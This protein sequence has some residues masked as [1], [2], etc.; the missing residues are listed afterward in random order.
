M[1]VS[2]SRSPN[3]LIRIWVVIIAVIFGFS[4][5]VFIFRPILKRLC[6]L[7]TNKCLWVEYQQYQNSV[8]AHTQPYGIWIWYDGQ[9]VLVY[10]LP[11]GRQCEDAGF[12]SAYV[13]D[14]T[15]N[16]L[17]GWS[18]ARSMDEV[19]RFYNEKKCPIQYFF[20]RELPSNFDVY[21]FINLLS[22]ERIISLKS[23]SQCSADS[24]CG[25]G[26]ICQAGTCVAGFTP[27]TCKVDTDCSQG[28]QCKDGVCVSQ[29]DCQK[30]AP[31]LS[32]PNQCSLNGDFLV[33]SD[34]KLTTQPTTNI[35]G[36]PF[37]NIEDTN[38]CMMKCAN[39][40][41][42]QLWSYDTDTKTCYGW[43][44][45]I[46]T[47]SQGLQTSKGNLLG[48]YKSAPTAS[49]GGTI[50]EDNSDCTYPSNCQ[51]YV[52]KPDPS[53]NIQCDNVMIDCPRK[54][55]CQTIQGMKKCVVP[56]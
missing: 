9:N 51:G 5:Y 35:T 53:A 30:Y 16:K 4:L 44:S 52:C 19:Q 41:L 54:M 15:T 18:C 31:N 7:D 32:T 1:N 36:S 13:I 12:E 55:V 50:C 20:K 37:S 33:Y 45:E 42:C 47:S 11:T 21:D 10:G 3:H 8:L 49:E 23:T 29:T 28:D 26:N 17:V 43:K 40:S 2:E 48:I 22:D 38:T 56:S 39:D 6:I 24:Q 34:T 27:K 14:I 46:P 25:I